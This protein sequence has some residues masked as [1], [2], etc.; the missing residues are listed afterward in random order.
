MPIR[1]FVLK[2]SLSLDPNPIT[3]EVSDHGDNSLSF[4]VVGIE[5]SDSR[6]LLQ[7]QDGPFYTALVVDGGSRILGS[8]NSNQMFLKVVPDQNNYLL[9]PSGSPVEEQYSIRIP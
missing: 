8:I 3:V 1:F 2:S 6:A 4:P 7:F 9:L 5:N